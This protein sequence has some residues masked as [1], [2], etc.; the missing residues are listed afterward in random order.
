MPIEK[1]ITPGYR[2]EYQYD[3]NGNPTG[4]TDKLDYVLGGGCLLPILVFLTIVLMV[5]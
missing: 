1:P 3:M 5:H 2:R 4:Y